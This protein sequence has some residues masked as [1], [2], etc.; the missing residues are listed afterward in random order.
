[1]AVI[2]GIISSNHRKNLNHIHKKSK[3]LVYVIITLGG[4]ISVGGTVF[5]YGMKTYDLGSRAHVLKHLHGIMIFG[6]FGKKI[7]EGTLWRGHR[8]VISFIL[9]KQIFLHFY[10]RGD[11]FY[12]WYINKTDKKI[13]FW[14]WYWG[15]TRKKTYKE[16]WDTHL[17]VIQY[18]KYRI[19]V[20]DFTIKFW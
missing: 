18:I 7:H 19:E 1:M 5:Y 8:S 10:H 17:V 4:N 12:N 14:W 2:G 6:P 3:Y 15:E 11:R 13:S 16:E 9:T 20:N